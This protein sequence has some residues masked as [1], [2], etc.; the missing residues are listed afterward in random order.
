M[1]GMSISESYTGTQEDLTIKQQI[2]MDLC[3]MEYV[4][5]ERQFTANVMG[6]KLERK[7]NRNIGVSLK[8][9]RNLK[10]PKKKGK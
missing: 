2:F 10:N 3:M 1:M 4:N 9:P 8:D 6:A 5:D 7:S